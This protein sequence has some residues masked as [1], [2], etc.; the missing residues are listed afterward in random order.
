MQP[1]AIHLLDIQILPTLIHDY[2]SGN[3]KLKSFYGNHPTVAG[4]KK[5]IETKQFSADNRKVLVEVLQQQYQNLNA[6]EKTRQ[7]IQL[8]LNENTFTVT[9]AH[10]TNVFTGPLYYI[11]KILHAVKLADELKRE[12]SSRH[13]VPVYW[14]GCED[15][16][17]DEINHIH[18][19]GEKLEWTDRQGGATG[20][21]NPQSLLEVLNS[22]KS[23]LS[24]EPFADEVLQIFEKGY[25]NYKTLAAATQ[26]IVN[27]LFGRYGLVVINPDTPELKKLFAPV[28][29]DELQHQSASKHANIAIGKLEALGYKIQAQPRDINLFYLDG[30]IRERIVWNEKATHYEVLN[31][32]L[33]FSKEALLALVDTH[34]EKFSPNVFLRPL[35]QET[36]LP[37]L[38]YI[39][40]AGELSYWLEQKEI[41]H[42]FNTTFPILVQRNSF[43]MIDAST[44]KKLQKLNLPAFDFFEEEDTIIKNYLALNNSLPDFSGEKAELEKIFSSLRDKAVAVDPT[45]KAAAEAQLQQALNN[46]DGLEKKM[47]RAIKQQQ[48]TGINQIKSVRNKL[49]P[50]NTLQERYENFLPYATQKGLGLLNELYINVQPLHSVIVFL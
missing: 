18:L 39:G 11:Y 42:Y 6:T 34:P 12:F 37:N 21:H 7:N 26:Y 1:N 27:E 49:M 5:Q 28:I 25:G 9:T 48:D 14:M 44:E 46:L 50:N 17:F 15:H 23:K 3:E 8:L 32:S 38:A 35:Y 4:F 45:L 30:N 22:V 20:R 10:Q 40:G 36:V 19:F 43:A 16:D 2:I 41:F 24:N 33:T 29:K 13:F 31:T 47:T